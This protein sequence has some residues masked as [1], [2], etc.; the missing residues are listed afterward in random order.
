VTYFPGSE[1]RFDSSYIDKNILSHIKLHLLT[2][3]EYKIQLKRK[4]KSHHNFNCPS[5]VEQSQL[6]FYS[7]SLSPDLI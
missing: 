3:L 7:D 1:K 5:S 2:R 4:S 6:Y